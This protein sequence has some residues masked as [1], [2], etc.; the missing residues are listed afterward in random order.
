MVELTELPGSMRLIL[1]GRAVALEAAA[2]VLGFALPPVCRAAVGGERAVLWL[3][4]DE[5][6]LLVP[7]ADTIAT[8]LARALAGL[9]HAL[10]DVGQRQVALQL[11]G[12]DATDV[13]NAGCPLDLHP[14]AFPVGMCTRTVLA[15]SEII[16]WR[17]A[18][19]TFRMDVVRSFAPYVRTF[20]REAAIG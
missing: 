5:F 12:P 13:L 6:L 15:K 7:E 10:V 14:D 16:L 9:P 8:D 2:D 19:D 1:R 4:P 11:R 3:G 18:T 17:T 20:L